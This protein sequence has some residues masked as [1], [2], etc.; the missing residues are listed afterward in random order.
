MS[1]KQALVTMNRDTEN[2]R[3][4]KARGSTLVVKKDLWNG[5][6]ISISKVRHQQD[7]LEWEEGLFPDE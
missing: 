1:R 3:F 4:G 7:Y 6:A 2:Q 5:R